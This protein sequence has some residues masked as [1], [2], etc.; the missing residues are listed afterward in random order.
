M[1]QPVKSKL[2]PI[3]DIDSVVYR[4]GYASDSNKDT[5]GNIIQEP[6]SYCLN[7]VKQSVA[8]IMDVFEPSEKARIFL[9]GG[10]NYRD[11][12]ASIQPYKGNRDPAKRPTWYAEIREYLLEFCGAELV[13][14]ME[15]D[16]ACGI[17]QWK[18][19]DKSTCIVS[20]DKDLDMIPG[21]HYNYVKQEMYY[22]NLAEANKKFWTQVLT[23]D[24]TDN[25]R[26]IPKVGIKT[27]EKLLA[28]VDSWMDMAAVASKAYADKGIADELAENAT[29]LWI[30]RE[31]MINYNG[32]QINVNDDS[33]RNN[34]GSS[35]ESESEETDG[36]LQE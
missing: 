26:G 31:H 7:S 3:V 34:S 12:L 19:K 24:T 6:L 11:R 1:G 33:T 5:E 8:A 10:G 35:S 17:E 36:E 22:V 14:G 15:T 9:Q 29:L 2:I 4:C 21:W 27:A 28:N 23:G 20:I 30:Q 18:Y 16:D 32:E 25:I 13:T